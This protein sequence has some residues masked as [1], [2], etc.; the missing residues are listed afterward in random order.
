MMAVS[1]IPQASRYPI[2]RMMARRVGNSTI[3]LFEWF[4]VGNTKDLSVNSDNLPPADNRGSKM[5]ERLIAFRELLIPDQELSESV[6][7]GVCR[8]DDPTTVLWWTPASALLSCD[9]W[10]VTPDAD[11]VANRFSVISLIRIQESP[12]SLRK[13]NHDGIEHCGELANVMSMGPADDQRQRD[14]TGVHQDVTLASL[15]S[16][17]LSGL[18]QLLPARGVL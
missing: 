2:R 3:W 17:G 18:D 10:S 5:K 15:F 9:P 6:E 12:S 14:A 8:L 1:F 4:W 11:L 13:G 7:P 16:P